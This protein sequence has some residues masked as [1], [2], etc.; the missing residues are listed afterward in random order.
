MTDTTDE[1]TD[2]E[3]NRPTGDEWPPIDA[4][5]GPARITI[6]VTRAVARQAWTAYRQAARAGYT[7]GFE[8]YLMN[9]T[10]ATYTVTVEGADLAT[11][12]AGEGLAAVEDVP[13]V[14]GDGT[15]AELEID[16]DPGRGSD[17]ETETGIEPGSERG[18][19]DDVEGERETDVESERGSDVEAADRTADLE[20]G[21]P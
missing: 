1:T 4:P 7:D 17:P 16:P 21:Q 6:D 15:E 18:T 2:T 13:T 3:T 14:V 5:L 12:L 20:D 11:V 8:T 19:E 9:H 10:S